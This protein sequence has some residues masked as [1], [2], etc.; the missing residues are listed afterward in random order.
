MDLQPGDQLLDLGC[1]AGLITEYISDQ[2]GAHVTGLN[3]SAP[4]VDLANERTEEKRDRLSYITGDMNARG[5]PE[6]AFERE[7]NGF[8]AESLIKESE[9]DFLPFIEAGDLARYLY[10]VRVPA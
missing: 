2:T 5:L 10:H 4:A 1:G 3:Y 6:G 9:V 8:M 7:G